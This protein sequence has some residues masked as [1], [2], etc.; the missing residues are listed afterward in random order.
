MIRKALLALCLGAF[1]G[2]SAPP[3]VQ[4][5]QQQSNTLGSNGGFVK[6][7][8][9]SPSGLG[10]KNVAADSAAGS[11]GSEPETT[12]SRRGAAEPATREGDVPKQIGIL[13]PVAFFMFLVLASGLY[14]FVF[15]KPSTPEGEAA[16]NGNQNNGAGTQSVAPGDKDAAIT[17]TDNR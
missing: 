7:G 9:S 3:R 6:P 14:W 5:Q 16:S 15:R 4:A 17:G 12:L 11:P 13:A 1:F 10:A 8:S 2:L